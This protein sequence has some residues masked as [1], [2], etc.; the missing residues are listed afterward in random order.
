MHAETGVADDLN[1]CAIRQELLDDPDFPDRVELTE[2]GEVVVSPR[3]WR[4]T[5]PLPFTGP[6]ARIGSRDSGLG[7]RRGAR[8]AGRLQVVVVFVE[9]N[10]RPVG[11]SNPC[12]N[13][14]RVVS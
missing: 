4:L 8:A 12:S 13:R 9:K 1:L 7:T 6:T 11:E 5:A 2:L 14:E 10:W 3:P